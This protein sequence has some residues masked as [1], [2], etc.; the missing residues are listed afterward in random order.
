[1]TSIGAQS[2]PPVPPQQAPVPPVTKPLHR[3]PVIE[4]ET[5][6]HWR[7]LVAD[8]RATITELGAQSGYGIGTVLRA[9]RGQ[10]AYVN[11]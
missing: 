7:E 5:V 10:G 9:I 8:G 2:I 4:R 1:M 3:R 6:W 11:I